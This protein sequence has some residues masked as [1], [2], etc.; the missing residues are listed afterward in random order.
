MSDPNPSLVSKRMNPIT[1]AFRSVKREQLYRDASSSRIRTQARVALVLGLALYT[2]VGIL[3]EHFLPEADLPTA[4]AIR[5]VVMSYAVA[6][7]AFTFHPSFQRFNQMPV[8]LVGLAAAAGLAGVMWL[9]PVWAVAEYYIA[10]VIVVFWTYLALGIRF[11]YGL[12]M[13]IA[14]FVVFYGTLA[15]LGDMPRPL[16]ETSAF[17]LFAGSVVAAGTAYVIEIQHRLL[18]VRRQELVH[19]RERHRARSLHDSLTGL[20]NRDLL[21]DR[22]EQAIAQSRRETLKCAGL[23]LDLDGFKLVNDTH[24][25]EAG[26]EALKIVSSRLQII[27]READTV[28]RLGGDE[29][30][31]V[32]RGIESAEAAEVLAKRVLV[33]VQE[34]IPLGNGSTVAVGVSIG[35]CM[36]PYPDCT[37][38]EIIQRADHAMYA[39]KRSGKQGFAFSGVE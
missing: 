14:I 17:F 8:A 37:P 28:A 23:Y 30:F 32:A 26:D 29:F 5:I 16:M 20:P 33:A 25:H 19:E 9:M 24:G 6:V 27:L 31:I 1:L 38:H 15:V 12:A 39:V 21:S 7:L 18:F 35:I 4:W 36:F 22:L 34:G 10:I 11:I 3:D 13:N 2:L